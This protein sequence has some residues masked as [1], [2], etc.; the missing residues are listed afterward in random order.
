MACREFSILNGVA[1]V[2]LIHTIAAGDTGFCLLDERLKW[3]RHG[4][5]RKSEK[6]QQPASKNLTGLIRFL[7]VPVKLF[8]EKTSYKIR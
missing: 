8:E 1:C 4:K 2:L 5:E 6:K 7:C 3:N